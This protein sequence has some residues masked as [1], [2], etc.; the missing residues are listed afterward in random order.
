MVE[1][2]ATKGPA[3]R[4]ADVATLLE[5][6]PFARF[7]GMEVERKG[8]ELTFILRYAP[9]LIG[10]PILP[11]LHGGVI[12]AFLEQSALLELVWDLRLERL[13]KPIDVSIDYLRPGHPV[14]TYARAV[15]T[16]RGRR[17]ANVRA[18]AWQDQRA[19]PI[20]ALHGHFMMSPAEAQKE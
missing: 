12:G 1:P 15:I 9:H 18:E 3:A 4:T 16:K 13:P 10:N 5:R 11:A 8:N 6:I 20:A 14:D 2:A 7:L 19:K 17:V